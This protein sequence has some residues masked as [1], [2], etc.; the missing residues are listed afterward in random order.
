MSGLPRQDPREFCRIIPLSFGK[1]QPSYATS[2][3]QSGGQ[4]NLSVSTG[5]SGIRLDGLEAA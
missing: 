1:A 4:V 3:V 2:R 5:L